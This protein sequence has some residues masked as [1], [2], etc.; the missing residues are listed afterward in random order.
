MAKAILDPRVKPGM[1]YTGG[2]AGGTD[3]H[4]VRRVTE[5]EVWSEKVSDNPGGWCPDR[6]G[7]GHGWFQ[8]G[9]FQF[10]RQMS[11]KEFKQYA[12]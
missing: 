8:K 12:P 11:K 6:H 10:I 7:S 1:V 4:V 9:D 3:E 5:D 2:S